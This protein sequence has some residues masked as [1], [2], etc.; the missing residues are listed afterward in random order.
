MKKGGD[1][2]LEENLQAFYSPYSLYS[3]YSLY[4][5][6][7]FYIFYSLYHSNTHKHTQ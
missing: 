2:F 4:S 7:I 5:F 3:S 6:Y 1:S